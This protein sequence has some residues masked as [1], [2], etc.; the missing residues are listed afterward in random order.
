MLSELEVSKCHG[1]HFFMTVADRLVLK[2]SKTK[3]FH[4]LFMKGYCTVFY[5]FEQDTVFVFLETELAICSLL[6]NCRMVN[7]GRDQWRKGLI[8]QHVL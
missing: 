8:M 2:C 7:I 5:T 1:G 6:Q 4:S 3:S